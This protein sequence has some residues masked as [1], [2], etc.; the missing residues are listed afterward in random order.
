LKKIKYP[1]FPVLIV[2]DEVEV[3][4]GCELTLRSCG[5]SNIITCLD[6]RNVIPLLAKQRIQV[7][8][9]DL[10]M[11]HVSGEELLRDIK[12]QYPHIPVIIVT[13][14]NQIETAIACMKAGAFDYMVKPVEGQRLISGIR[15]VVDK[16]EERNE[17]QK[18]KQ[19]VLNDDLNDSEAFSQI[20]TQNKKMRSIFQYVEAVAGTNQ[21]VLITGDS[22]VGKGLIAKAIHTISLRSGSFVRV[23]IAGLDDNFFSDSLF[24]HLKGAFT[25]AAEKRQGL[26]EQATDGTLFLDEIG[27]LNPSG[28]IKLLRLL[29]DG[30]Y[31][32]VGSDFLKKTNARFV[33]ATNQDIHSLQK[34]KKFRTDLYFRFQI[35]HIHIPSLRERFDDLPLL[36][37]YFLEESSRSLGKKKPTPPKELLLLLSSYHFPGNIRE[38]RSMIFDALTYHKSKMLSMKRFEDHILK[39]RSQNEGIFEHEEQKN[40]LYAFID[41]LPTLKMARKLLIAE[42]LKRCH[43]NITMAAP[44]LG[45]SQSGL[46]KLLKREEL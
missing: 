34:Q 26:I 19:L 30:E 17:Y 6:S 4:Q 9:L 16:L 10:F 24:G 28:Q 8:L 39:H 22:G 38:L 20:I 7:I 3:I 11:P 23:N 33:A 18:F 31:F 44:L 45:I 13:G 43:G 42:V 27:D 41:Q 46:S 1:E 40:T 32:P 14:M 29:E 36:L 15:H 2:D 37:D 5:I 12:Q 21:P 25:S 35:H